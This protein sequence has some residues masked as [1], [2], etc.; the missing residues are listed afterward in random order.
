MPRLLVP[1]R[2]STL[3]IN[4]LLFA[5][6]QLRVYWSTNRMHFQVPY[7][8]KLYRFPN[9]EASWFAKTTIPTTSLTSL[10]WTILKYAGPKHLE[11]Y[12]LTTNTRYLFW[13]LVA[14]NYSYLATTCSGFDFFQAHFMLQMEWDYVAGFILMLQK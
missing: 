11:A 12:S 3:K 4:V 2:I 10:T 9:F 7:L 1:A 8:L 13:M 5:F 6:H 14:R